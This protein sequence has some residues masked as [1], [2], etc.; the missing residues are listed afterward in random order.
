MIASILLALLLATIVVAQQSGTRGAASVPLLQS[1]NGLNVQDGTEGDNSPQHSNRGP[2]SGSGSRSPRTSQGEIGNFCDTGSS[3]T[4]SFSTPCT[5]IENY[6]SVPTGKCDVG[7]A[8]TC[9]ER[10]QACTTTELEELELTEWDLV[11]GCDR[12]TYGNECIA[13]LEGVNVWH[14]G[15]CESGNACTD[16]NPCTNTDKYFCKFPPGVFLLT[17]LY[18]LYLVYDSSLLNFFYSIPIY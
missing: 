9:Q 7:E 8:G 12:N 17:L 13:A 15:E 4:F 14:E 1:T 18:L 3:G 5:S 16:E 2:P 11:C 6:C 10:P